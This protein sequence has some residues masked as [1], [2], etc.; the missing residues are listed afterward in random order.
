MLGFLVRRI[1]MCI[2]VLWVISVLT[3][4][5]MLLSPGDPIN[6]YINPEVSR[7][8]TPEAIEMLRHKMGLDRPLILQYFHWIGNFVQGNWGFSFLSKAPV[9]RDILLRLPNTLLLSGSALLLS[10]LVAIPVGIMSAVKQYSFLDYVATTTAFFGIS[11]PR[12]WF[13]LMLTYVFAVQLRW[14]PSTG[15]SSVRFD[16]TA[17]GHFVDVVRHLVLPTLALALP[18]MASWARYQRSSLLETLGQDYV[19]TARAKGLR[20]RIVIVRHAA[21][22]AMIPMVTLAGL[23]LPALVGGSYIVETIFGWPGMGRLGL[24][25]IMARDY[26]VIMGVTMTTAAV[27]LLG[28]LLADVAYVFVDPRIQYQ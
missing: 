19:R 11:I 24:N 7:S 10:T 2:L 8:I 16:L 6:I 26:P 28:N 9:L 4:I 5:L 23:T 25:A 3:F 20:E 14:L 21:R 13:A 18:S 17:W 12:F 1:G 27:V 15:M 22:N